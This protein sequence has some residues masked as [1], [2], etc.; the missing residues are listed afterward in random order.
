MA[1]EENLAEGF[2]DSA[3]GFVDSYVSYDAAV[4]TVR[5]S[6]GIR[7]GYHPATPLTVAYSAILAKIVSGQIEEPHEGPEC[8]KRQVRPRP[9][10]RHHK[11]CL[12]AARLLDSMGICMHTVEQTKD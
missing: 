9:A 4:A 7:I 8:E 1:L 11:L 2:V 5:L 3:E 12:G 10:D 6:Q